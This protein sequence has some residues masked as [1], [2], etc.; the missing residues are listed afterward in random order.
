MMSLSLLL[1]ALTLSA[2]D[3]AAILKQVDQAASRASDM[4]MTLDIAVSTRGSE[5]LRR[6]LK[7]WQLGSDQRMVKFTAP[8]RLRGTGILKTTDHTSLYT[9][10]YKRVR[11]IAGKQGGGSFMGTGFSINDLAR[12]RFSDDY[13]ATLGADTIGHWV[14]VLKPNKPDD[15]RH[16][17]L[18]LEVRQSDH[19]VHRITTLDAAG[20]TM[21]TIVAD[22]F[23][24]VG[25]YTIAHHIQIDEAAS[26][27]RTVAKIKAVTFDTG[28]SQAW[29]SERQLKRAP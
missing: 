24:T 11:R 22:Q 28:L 23:K 14:L 7:V 6:S 8:A 12:V 4:V 15:H 1:S 29:F 13:M 16:A 21:R 17:L 25:K 2:P 3:P 19:L 26:G 27:K 5:P 10:A 20:K 18:K 9:A